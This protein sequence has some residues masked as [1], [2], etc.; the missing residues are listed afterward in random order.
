LLQD[1]RPSEQNQQTK[2]RKVKLMKKP[3]SLKKGGFSLVELLV[4][5]A[6]IAIIAAIAIPNIANITGSA[7]Q[8][9]AQRSA[10]N[11]ASVYS[12]AVA[13]GATQADLGNTIEA[14][15]TNLTTGVTVQ[16]GTQTMGPFRVD[17]FPPAGDARTRALA[18]LTFTPGTGT[19]PGVLVYNPEGSSSSSDSSDN[20]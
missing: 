2:R 15:V 9:A 12:A 8:S 11:L 6:V 13:A 7:E 10:Q 4:V 18:Y 5:I 20:D 17:A 14:V 3:T 16:V 1:K 19:N